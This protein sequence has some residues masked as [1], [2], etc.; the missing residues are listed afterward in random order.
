MEFS[1]E[2]MTQ[3]RMIAAAGYIV[4][5]VPLIWRPR[6]RLGRY[7]ANQGLL[8]ALVHLIVAIFFH[9]LG[10]IP[11]IG[12]LF[13]IVAGLVRLGLFIIALGC[14]ALLLTNGSVTE[15]PYIGFLRLIP[16][17]EP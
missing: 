3:N 4:F 6:S 16:D 9:I 5:F 11:L 12:W 7:C 10:G 1:R 2:D 17:V 15:L 14:G 8:L 13:G